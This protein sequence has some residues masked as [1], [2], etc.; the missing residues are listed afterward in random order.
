MAKRLP[1]SLYNPVSAVGGSLAFAS[2]VTIL[3]LTFLDVLQTTSPAYIGIIAYVVL[4]LPLLIGILLFII[5]IRRERKRIR[6]GLPASKLVFTVDFNSTR[7]RRA[8]AVLGTAAV[9]FFVFTA[10]G[11]YRVFE[12]TESVEFCGEMCHSVMEPEYTAYQHS[13]HARV[14]CV[15][16]H[17]GSGAGWYVQSKLSGAYQVYSVLAKAYS[18]PIPTPIS[19]LRPARETCEECH[20]PAAFIGEKKVSNRYFRSDEQ[21]SPWNVALL[22]KIGG[23]GG[24]RTAATGIHWHTS[25]SHQVFFRASDSLSQVIPWVRVVDKETGE[26]REYVSTESEVPQAGVH[27]DALHLMDCIDCHNRPSHI[28]RPPVR[29]VDHSIAQGHISR[30][31][32]GIRGAAIQTLVAEYTST[33]AAMDSIPLVLGAFYRETYPEIAESRKDLIAAAGEELKAQFRQ[34][35]FP[36]MKVNWKAYPNNIGHMTAA[37]CFRCHDGK[38]VTADG[39]VLTKDCNDCHT[40]LYQGPEA[41]PGVYTTGGAEFQHPED[42]GDAW[43]ETNCHDC[44]TGQ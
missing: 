32:P 41:Q 25:A 6:R 16:C 19:N 14:A 24:E 36:Y 4:P 42:I 18:Q 40:I 31:L 23:G 8:A 30:D 1:D 15:E 7:H 9:L 38:H 39:K 3:F 17:V 5:G 35:I 2:F 11:S 20:W 10:Y 26:A 22:M 28:Y 34:N 27:A 21:N 44:H 43:K 13:P 12:W 33:A 29:I 37:G